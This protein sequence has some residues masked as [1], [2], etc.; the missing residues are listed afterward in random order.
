MYDLRLGYPGSPS[1]LNSSLEARVEGQARTVYL[2]IVAAD[3]AVSFIGRRAAAALRR[4]ASGY[5]T[6]QRRRRT[7]QELSRLDPRMLRD[8]GVLPGEI[9]QIAAG[10]AAARDR[11]SIA[12]ADRRDSAFT[13]SLPAHEFDCP[14]L[15]HA[16]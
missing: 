3:A 1:Y 2:L 12:P 15:K 5:T 9:E 14:D 13:P 10:L 6:W 4:L 16:A 11:E 8:I 7:A